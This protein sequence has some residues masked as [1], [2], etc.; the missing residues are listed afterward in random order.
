MPE[1]TL[2]CEQVEAGDY[3]ARYLADRLSP[4]EAEEYEAHDFGCERCW[5][6]LRRARDARA[7]FASAQRGSAPRVMRWA[8]PLAAAAVAVVVWR[9]VAPSTDAPV[10][11][12]R[13]AT[14][15]L[16][17]SVVANRDSI[18]A[19]WPRRPD[20]D[21]YRVRGF[22]ADG[23]LLWS[24]ETTD[25]SLTAVRADAGLVDVAA[26]DRLRVVV[27]QSRPVTITTP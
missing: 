7:A 25:T 12:V 14:S 9:I 2:S 11:S 19:V 20:V 21:R 3:E 10:T 22:T 8:L 18:H 4:A 5:A 6:A 17:L 26:L 24:L 23:A 15:A 27:A 13:G 16:T 1:S